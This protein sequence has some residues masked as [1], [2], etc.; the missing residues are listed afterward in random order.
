MLKLRLQ[1]V[2]RNKV[3][4]F[5]LVLAE[6]TMP[7]QGRFIEKLGNFVAGQKDTTL[8][9]EKERLTYWLS[10]GAQPSTTVAAIL[11]KAGMKEFAPFVKE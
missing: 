8:V 7:V 4:A 11:V 10:K 9:L 3:P 2:G 6:H 1:R 5:R